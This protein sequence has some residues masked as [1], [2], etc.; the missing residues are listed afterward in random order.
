M[1][2]PYRIEESVLRIA[3]RS[4]IKNHIEESS[5]NRKNKSRRRSTRR[6]KELESNPGDFQQSDEPKKTRPVATSENGVGTNRIPKDIN[7]EVR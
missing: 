3:T 1:G 2:L 7:E 4:S 6:R 5:S